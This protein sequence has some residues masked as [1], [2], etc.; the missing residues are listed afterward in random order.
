M[1][2]GKD[3]QMFQV[4]MHNTLLVYVID[5]CRDLHEEV[6]GMV[7]RQELYAVGLQI[8]AQVTSLSEFC[9]LNRLVIEFELFD[10]ANYILVTLA[11]PKSISF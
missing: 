1:I 8:H 11:S 2:A 3:I 4:S 7:F 10:K 6:L 9:N 5:S